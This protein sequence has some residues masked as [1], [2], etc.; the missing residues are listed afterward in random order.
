M[1][2]V[3]AW[4]LTFNEFEDCDQIQQNRTVEPKEFTRNKTIANHNQISIQPV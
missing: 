1:S 3:R 4:Q 2:R